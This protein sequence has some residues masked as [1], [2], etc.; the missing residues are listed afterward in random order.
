MDILKIREPIIED[1]DAF[2]LASNNSKSLHKSWVKP[3]LTK[4]EFKAYIE[5]S[6]LYNQKCFLVCNSLNN[7]VGVFNISEIVLGG[8][9]SA[10]LGFYAMDN[11]SGKGYMSK[12]LKLVL[13]N[14]FEEIK[15]HRIEANIQPENSHSINLVKA[16]GFSKEGYS[17]KYLNIDGK[18]RDHERWAVT[19]ENWKEQTTILG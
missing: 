13:K 4:K 10:Y 8:F 2:L 11:Y 17:P 9:H 3:P 19:Y 1:Q 7:I 5:R 18:W 14:I 15:L 12:G 6:K 16:N